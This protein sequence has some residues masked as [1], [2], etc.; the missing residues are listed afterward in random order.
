MRCQTCAHVVV[1]GSASSAK[2]AS[3]TQM[4]AKEYSE[5]FTILDNSD[6]V[7]YNQHSEDGTMK[8]RE[9]T[10]N[11]D[12]A[13]ALLKALEWVIDTRKMSVKLN[14]TKI[15][16]EHSLK[17]PELKFLRSEHDSAR[18]VWVVTMTTPNYIKYIDYAVTQMGM[19]LMLDGSILTADNLVIPN[20]YLNG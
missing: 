8:D 3:V 15:G 7:R 6:W 14:M 17:I 20:D 13:L 11:E 12:R 9:L 5:V 4:S 10:P 1:S 16:Y 19:S 2:K 18:D